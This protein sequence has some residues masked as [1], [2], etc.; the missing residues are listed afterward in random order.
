M[1][2]GALVFG[3][4]E[5]GFRVRWN[6]V[7]GKRNGSRGAVASVDVLMGGETGGIGGDGMSHWVAKS[8]SQCNKGQRVSRKCK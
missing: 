3:S 8:R 4:E 7:D 6:D 2:E 1:G 5:M